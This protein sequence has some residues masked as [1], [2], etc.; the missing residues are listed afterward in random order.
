MKI[1]YPRRSQ[2]TPILEEWIRENLPAIE[3]GK[4]LEV[5]IGMKAG[6][7]KQEAMITITQEAE[8][9]ETDWRYQAN[10]FPCRIKALAQALFNQGVWGTYRT[11]H[12][13]GTLSL[14]KVI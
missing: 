11:S 5:R 10:T 2:F 8:A 12:W 14:Q 7:I 6:M 1:R 9:F 13:E 3:G 4:H